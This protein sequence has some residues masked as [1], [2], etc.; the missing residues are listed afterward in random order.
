VA[1]ALAI[2]MLVGWDGMM[3]AGCIELL[4]KM[5]DSMGS[6]GEQEKQKYGDRA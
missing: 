2:F 6:R 3:I 1:V 5:M 4:K